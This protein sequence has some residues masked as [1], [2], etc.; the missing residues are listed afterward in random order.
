MVLDPSMGV[1]LLKCQIHSHL[2]VIRE[3]IIRLLGLGR[4]QRSSGA[5]QQQQPSSHLPLSVWRQQL[6]SASELPPLCERSIARFKTCP[7]IA[8][9][10]TSETTQWPSGGWLVWLF[11]L[12]PP[13]PVIPQDTQIKA[14]LDKT[15][16]QRGVPAEKAACQ[17]R[18]YICI[19]K[20]YYNEYLD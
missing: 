8:V 12:H 13:L 20:Y 9:E 16:S 2:K 1:E 18:H 11:T 17:K 10:T 3:L 5:N 15:H 7:I 6:G 4:V 19:P 14:C